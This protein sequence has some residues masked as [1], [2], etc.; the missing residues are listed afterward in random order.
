MTIPTPDTSA[1]A[2][3]PDTLERSA[4]NIFAR[5]YQ[6]HVP[7]GDMLWSKVST[8]L[9][10]A[11]FVIVRA[12]DWRDRT[13]SHAQLMETVERL[14]RERD[15]FD[16][17]ATAWAHQAAEIYGELKTVEAEVER[18]IRE[19]D[20]LIADVEARGKSIVAEFQA[21]E[22][23]EAA[24]TRLLS[25]L[26]PFA[27]AVS[28]DEDGPHV[29]TETVAEGEWEEAHLALASAA[30]PAAPPDARKDGE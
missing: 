5:V 2:V 20:D 17:S 28:Y 11:G 15:A 4:S 16:R 18:L 27:D 7:R 21:R 9:L 26:K 29:E 12:A 3:K 13:A 6:S 25:I 14:T 23:A 30:P 8:A 24:V 19:R 10:A 22:T 1:A